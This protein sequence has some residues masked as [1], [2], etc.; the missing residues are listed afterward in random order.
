MVEKE[1]R[2]MTNFECTL[3]RREGERIRRWREKDGERKMKS[4][5]ERDVEIQGR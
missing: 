4:E 3:F 1:Y 5:K 2:T